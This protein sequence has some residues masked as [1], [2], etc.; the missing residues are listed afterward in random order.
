MT[1]TEILK[2][3][4]GR[5]RILKAIHE[6]KNIAQEKEWKLQQHYADAD[7]I[8]YEQIQWQKYLPSSYFSLQTLL[9][10]IS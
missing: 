9:K 6:M 2:E 7:P 1:E 3:T 5:E 4:I 8:T 10:K